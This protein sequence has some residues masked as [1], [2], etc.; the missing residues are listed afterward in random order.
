MILSTKYIDDQ[1]F[2]KNLRYKISHNI[3][4]AEQLRVFK[5][6]ILPSYN[7]SV[8]I[9]RGVSDFV[10]IVTTPTVLQTEQYKVTLPNNGF[11]FKTLPEPAFGSPQECVTTNLTLQTQ[12]ECQKLQSYFDNI[13]IKLVPVDTKL[14]AVTLLLNEVRS[15]GIHTHQYELVFQFTDDWSS[16]CETCRT[17]LLYLQNEL[18]KLSNELYVARDTA[19]F[20]GRIISDLTV[21]NISVLKEEI[22]LLLSNALT[23]ARVQDFIINDLANTGVLV[24]ETEEARAGGETF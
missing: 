20:E 6:T 19:E 24:N 11:S 7:E 13:R 22:K 17:G 18:N 12:I 15:N 2:I 16:T 9:L 21:N 5:E 8:L 3:N 10:E 14:D 23:N 4:S 1:G